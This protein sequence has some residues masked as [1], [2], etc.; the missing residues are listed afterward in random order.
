MKSKRKPGT[1]RDRA[2]VAAALLLFVAALALRWLFWQATPDAA[3]PYSACYKGDAPVWLAYAEA[4]RE[5]RPFELG[6]P[7]RPPGAAYLIYVG[8]RTLA[9]EEKSREDASEKPR[10]YMRLYVEGVV[11]NVLN[12]KSILFFLAFLPQFVDVERGAIRFQLFLLGMIFITLGF[13][14]DGTYSMFYSLILDHAEAEKDAGLFEK[15]LK[16]LKDKYGDKPRNKRFFDGKDAILEKLRG[17][18]DDAGQ[19]PGSGGDE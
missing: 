13:I 9:G 12:P 4:L 14:S 10:H 16:K 7:M 3:W 17:G 1:A 2:P 5:G 8:L 11:V 6:L 19:G 15:A 18:G